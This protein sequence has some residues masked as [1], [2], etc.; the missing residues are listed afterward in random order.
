MEAAGTSVCLMMKAVLLSARWAGS[1]RRLGLEQA[2]VVS[3]VRT[4]MTDL[5]GL[6]CDADGDAPWLVH[7]RS[8]RT[9]KTSRPLG[10]DSRERPSISTQTPAACRQLFPQTHQGQGPNS[11]SGILPHDNDAC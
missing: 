4:E 5:S 2:A 7:V 6:G 1:S 9:Q 10:P 11:I 3:R 8:P